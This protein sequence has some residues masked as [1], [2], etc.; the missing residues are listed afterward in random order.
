MDESARQKGCHDDARTRKYDR[1]DG[2]RLCHGPVRPE[3]PTEHDENECGRADLFSK[4]VVFKS[5]IDRTIRAE[6]HTEQD[7]GEKHRDAELV[8]DTVQKHTGKDHNGRQEQERSH[9]RS[10]FTTSGKVVFFI[11]SEKAGK[12]NGGSRFMRIVI[13]SEVEKSSLQTDKGRAK[14]ERSSTQV[15]FSRDDD[16][17]ETVF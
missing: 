3:A 6:K 5:N 12:D 8:R 16:T 1:R 9:R 10:P 14:V 7:K 15:L 17:G 11:V 13:S 4:V 2:D